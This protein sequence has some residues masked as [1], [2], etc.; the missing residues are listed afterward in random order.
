[1]N[2][3]S[4]TPIPVLF[5]DGEVRETQCSEYVRMYLTIDSFMLVLAWIEM[6][7]EDLLH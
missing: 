4:I 3:A 6:A 7:L 2:S 5:V 1:M